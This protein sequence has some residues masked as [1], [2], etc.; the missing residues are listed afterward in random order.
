MQYG[1]PQNGQTRNSRQQAEPAGAERRGDPNGQPNDPQD[2]QQNGQQNGL[3]QPLPPEPNGQKP[4]QGGKP[5]DSM[6]KEQL[7]QR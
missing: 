5:E 2:G 4:Q 3:N 1:D 6:T 7:K